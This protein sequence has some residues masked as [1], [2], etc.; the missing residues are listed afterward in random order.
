M[1]PAGYEPKSFT[2]GDVCGQTPMRDLIN[3][4]EINVLTSF[5][6]TH[7]SYSERLD[8]IVGFFSEVEK[9][10]HSCFW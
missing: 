5:D 10:S 9:Y 3:P 7:I 4:R 1:V 6:N 8:V 2:F